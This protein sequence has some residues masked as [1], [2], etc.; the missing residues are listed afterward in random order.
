MSSSQ[1][2]PSREPGAARHRRA[3]DA[4]AGASDVDRLLPGEDPERADAHDAGLWVDVYSELL[5]FKQEM[6][7]MV[8]ARVADMKF[9]PAR[10]EV[11]ETDAVVL[12]AEA[13]RLAGR[14]GYWRRRLDELSK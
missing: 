8:S 6:L 14:L 1:V 2:D 10:Q 11:E 4:A 12:R 3:R 7:Q 5:L 9:D 13:E